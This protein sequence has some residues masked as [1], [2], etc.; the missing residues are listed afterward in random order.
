MLTSMMSLKISI[1]LDISSINFVDKCVPLPTGTM[2]QNRNVVAVH[3]CFK[4]LFDNTTHR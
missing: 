2:T 4:Y 1:K 3:D